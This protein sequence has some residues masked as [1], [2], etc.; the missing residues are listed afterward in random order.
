[1]Y[2][3]MTLGLGLVVSGALHH[4]SLAGRMR[5]M[6]TLIALFGLLT[7]SRNGVWTDEIR[8]WKDAVTKNPLSPRPHN[9][10]GKAYHEDGQLEQALFHFLQANENIQQGIAKQYN[11]TDPREVLERRAGKNV[12]GEALPGS[13]KIVADLA[14]PLRNRITTWPACIWILETLSKPNRSIKPPFA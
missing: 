4:I 6:V 7:L 9:N 8:L 12:N 10:L 13:L 2:L 14:E 5:F 1:M 3:P 11:L